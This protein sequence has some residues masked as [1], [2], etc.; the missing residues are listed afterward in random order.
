MEIGALPTVDYFNFS[1]DSKCIQRFISIHT[2]HPYDNYLL[3]VPNSIYVVRLRLLLRLMTRGTC[4]SS[5]MH[6]R[7]EVDKEA[8]NVERE[9]KCNCPFED[10]PRVRD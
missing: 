10:R 5:C 1:K 8:Y 9:Y 6:C 4:N 2:A 7:A 3:K